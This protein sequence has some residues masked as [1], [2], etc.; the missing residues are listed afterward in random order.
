MAD[1]GAFK[2]AKRD[3]SLNGFARV[4]ALVPETLC[5]RLL[6][7]LRADGGVPVGDPS[8][9]HD[10]ESWDIVPIWGTGRNGRSASCRAS[11]AS[12]LRCGIRRPLRL[13]G[14]GA[15]HTAVA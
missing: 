15:L 9:W 2:Q 3:I 6:E 8:R 13:A 10:Y 12:G 11:I 1:S 4:P 5:D 14:H 7:A